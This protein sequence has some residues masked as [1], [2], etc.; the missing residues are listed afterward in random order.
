MSLKEAV[1]KYKA[2]QEAEQKYQGA[3]QRRDQLQFHIDWA[4]SRGE[5]AEVRKL[6]AQI[7]PLEKSL[8]KLERELRDA[9]E[10]FSRRSGKK[11]IE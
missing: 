1:R 3:L 11:R 4:K 9:D 10:E 8:D 5:P 6:E 2:R 7:E